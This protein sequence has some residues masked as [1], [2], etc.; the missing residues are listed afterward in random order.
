MLAVDFGL[1]TTVV[2]ISLTADP[3]MGVKHVTFPTIVG[4]SKDFGIVVGDEAVE[5]SDLNPKNVF[6]GNTLTNSSLGSIV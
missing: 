3:K 1:K 6:S 2:A 5:E 4:F